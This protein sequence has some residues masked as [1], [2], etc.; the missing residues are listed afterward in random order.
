[1]TLRLPTDPMVLVVAGLAVLLLLTAVLAWRANRKLRRELRALAT[2]VA[3]SVDD[4]G[5]VNERIDSL[6][7]I[8]DAHD[9]LLLRQKPRP[10]PVSVAV[11]QSQDWVDGVMGQQPAPDPN[12]PTTEMPRVIKTPKPQPAE[13]ATNLIPRVIKTPKAE[14]EPVRG[15]ITAS[16]LIARYWA[17]EQQRKE[18]K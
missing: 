4:L 1:M 15:P 10:I 12:P 9:Q 3:G 14:P 18:G 8:V 6:G 17:E 7:S 13:P 2:E 16:T 11:K 5:D